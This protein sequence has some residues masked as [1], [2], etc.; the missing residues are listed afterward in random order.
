MDTSTWP[1]LL[2]GGVLISVIPRPGGVRLALPAYHGVNPDRGEGGRATL[3]NGIVPVDPQ[4]LAN[5]DGQ[6]AVFGE[7]D[8]DGRKRVVHRPLHY[9]IGA[10]HFRL[11]ASQQRRQ[12]EPVRTL[13][14]PLG[15]EVPSGPGRPAVVRG[16]PVPAEC[17]FVRVLPDDIGVEPVRHARKGEGPHHP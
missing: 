14:D 1:C 3:R 17:L 16:Y 9:W 7:V 6:L 5:G 11:D 8:S 4:L 2:T 10:G 12:I 15:G 13:C